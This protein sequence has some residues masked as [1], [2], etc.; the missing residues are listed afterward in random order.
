MYKIW[1]TIL[2]DNELREAYINFTGD[3]EEWIDHIIPYHILEENVDNR[4]IK[5]E[6]TENRKNIMLVKRPLPL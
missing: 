3:L 6:K 1:M 4:K 5:K 2:E